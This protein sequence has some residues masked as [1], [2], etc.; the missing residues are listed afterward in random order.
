MYTILLEKERNSPEYRNFIESLK[1][2]ITQRLYDRHLFKYQKYIKATSLNELLTEDLKIIKNSLTSYVLYLRDEKKVSYSYMNIAL[3]ALKHF[4]EMNEVAGISWSKIGRF[5]GENKRSTS[6]RAYTH[7]EIKRMLEVADI[8]YRAIILT[9]ASTGMR[10]E[11][12]IS[13]RYGDMERVNDNV[14]RFIVYRRTRNEHIT[15]CTPECFAAI[16]TYLQT[17]IMAGEAL[18][19]D[20]PLF[21]RDFDHRDSLKAKK[22]QPI[23]AKTLANR[24]RTISH[25]ALVT[26]PIPNTETN[27]EGRRRNEVA[28]V[29]GFRKFA[30]T[31][32]GR[33]KINPEIREILVNHD[34][35][36]RQVYLKYDENDLLSEYVKAIDNL[37]IN[38]ENRLKKQLKEYKEKESEVSAL[39]K[40]LEDL[41]KM[42]EG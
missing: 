14:Y 39:R 25:N 17:R 20:S 9:Y 42:V 22:P 28:V 7:E 11:A 32:M 30:I 26:K 33:A 38:P 19:S 16:N 21:R 3:S 29:H 35:G 40:D 18:K 2:K 12:L 37:T 34:L 1:S 36:I 23:T 24:I 41:R 8:K 15:F 4:Y 10:R 27:P 13:L 31:E 6:D 5:K